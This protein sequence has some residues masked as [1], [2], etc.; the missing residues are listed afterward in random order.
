MKYIYNLRQI[1]VSTTVFSFLSW[2]FFQNNL[3]GKLIIIP[4]LICSF[5]LC[6]KNVF[7]I[8][9]KKKLINIFNYIFRISL[10][11]YIFGFLIFAIF[12]AIKN[13]NYSLFIIVGIFS[14][15]VIHFLKQ[16]KYF[17]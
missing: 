1:I 7:I 17:K 8:L 10:L 11:I 14:I 4:F 13:K 5:A 6:W 15:A 12:Y 16:N 2:A 3:I 9:N